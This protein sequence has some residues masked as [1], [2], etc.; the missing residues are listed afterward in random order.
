MD[1]TDTEQSDISLVGMRIKD[2]LVTLPRGTEV[3]M[4]NVDTVFAN[5]KTDVIF[6]IK[7]SKRNYNGDKSNEFC[8]VQIKKEGDK[9]IVEDSSLVTN[10]DCE[11]FHEILTICKNINKNAVDKSSTSSIVDEFKKLLPP[12][13]ECELQHQDKNSSIEILYCGGRYTYHI[14]KSE[15]QWFL[16]IQEICT[17]INENASD[18]SFIAT[19][20]E[21]LKNLTHKEA[22]FYSLRAVFCNNQNDILFADDERAPSTSCESKQALEAFKPTKRANC[23]IS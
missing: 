3:S 7:I 18:K 4:Q 1:T 16:K 9:Y 23:V 5:A 13:Y 2:I 15:K 6:S 11:S 8:E 21:E 14:T 10:S 19:K 22:S 20:L 17:S 12:K